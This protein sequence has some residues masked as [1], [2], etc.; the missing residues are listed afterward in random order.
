MMAN[1]LTPRHRKFLNLLDQGKTP[2]EAYLGSLPSGMA[3]GKDPV[4]LASQMLAIGVVRAE[5]EK[6]QTKAAEAAQLSGAKV[7]ERWEALYAKASTN[8]D[9]VTVARV[10]E[11]Q[12]KIV[13]LYIEK[14]EDVSKGSSLTDQDA[15]KLVATVVMALMPVLAKYRV[16]E[17][18]ATQALQASFAPHLSTDTHGA[19]RGNTTH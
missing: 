13:G 6:R 4:K 17:S 3:A 15:A 16:P 11:N 18:E 5:H 12:G 10:L 1:R 19:G 8:N 2:A 7:I 14:T 9:S